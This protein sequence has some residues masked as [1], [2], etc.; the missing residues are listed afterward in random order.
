MKIHN[1]SVENKLVENELTKFKTELQQKRPKKTIIMKPKLCLNL[2][3][4]ILMNS[5]ENCENRIKNFYSTSTDAINEAIKISETSSSIEDHDEKE[6][7]NSILLEEKLSEINESPQVI[8]KCVKFEDSVEIID[9]SRED[10]FYSNTTIDDIESVLS[11]EIIKKDENDTENIPQNSTEISIK[12]KFTEDLKMDQHNT[13]QTDIK[14]LLD[15]D[16][17][18][19]TKLHTEKLNSIDNEKKQNCENNCSTTDSTTDSESDDEQNKIIAELLKPKFP[20]NEILLRKY[21]LKWIHFVTLEKLEKQNC[22]NR[23]TDQIQKINAFLD[24]IRREKARISTN[25]SVTSIVNNNNK[26]NMVILAKKY[27]NKLVNFQILKILFYL[28]SFYFIQSFL[29]IKIQQDIIEL[30]KLK[31]ERQ[32]RMIMTLKLSKLSEE[33]KKA[34]EDIK[35]ELK[36][37]IRTGDFKKR[38]K[39]KCLQLVGSLRDEEDEEFEK[40]QGKSLMTPKFLA[41]MQE[42]ALERSIKHEQA[43]QRRLQME[44]EKEAAKMAAEEAKVR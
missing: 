21:F 11:D 9:Y 33:A 16:L 36:S 2:T 13:K 43:R 25:K 17:L 1:R 12:Q 5:L 23:T 4:E 27:K 42:R 15:D 10:S 32:E 6:N 37:V 24:N 34:R 39:A 20:P 22:F 28:N 26:Q 30:Q 3:N 18:K 31:L 41:R 40:L 19:I 8:D 35:N 44:A 14:L 38:A 29:R 7:T